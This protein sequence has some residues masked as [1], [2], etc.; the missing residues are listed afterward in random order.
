MP[1]N[2]QQ[3]QQLS[4]NRTLGLRPQ[5]ELS[6][7]RIFLST[8]VELH[9][10]YK[11]KSNTQ[12]ITLGTDSIEQAI[13]LLHGY[14]DSWRSFEEMLKQL[15]LDN[16]NQPVFALDMRGHGESSS[17]PNA[18]TQVDFAD[19]IAAFMDKLKIGKAVVVGHSMGG[20]VAHQFAVSYPNKVEALVLIAT[21]ATMAG[22]ALIAEIKPIIDSFDPDNPAPTDFVEEF[23]SSTFY[24]GA[25]PRVA[26]RYVSDS[27]RLRGLVWQ[28]T[29][30]DLGKE[31]HRDLLP[32]IIA[33]TLILW[34]DQDNVFGEEEQTELR[35][36][37]PNSTLVIF[38]DA[39]HALNVERVEGVVDAIKVFVD[40]ALI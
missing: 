26:H 28:E 29:L 18:Y 24:K 3:K 4:M 22:S 40:E 32:N 27:L 11:E 35:N 20:L 33:P 14:T 21:T 10:V 17:E 38:H 9:Y 36:L 34:G 12:P 1:T 6:L 25:A 16:F 13:I 19:D 23:Q 5:L 30:N 2:T 39:G 7:F 8:G 31:D 15:P 37:I